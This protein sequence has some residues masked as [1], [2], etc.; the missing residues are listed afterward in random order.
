MTVPG[1]TLESAVD[2]TSSLCQ[3]V[4]TFPTAR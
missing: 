2:G 1:E 4:C 3:N